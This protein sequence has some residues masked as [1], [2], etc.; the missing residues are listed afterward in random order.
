MIGSV[1]LL[2]AVIGWAGY[3]S[4]S[5]WR[6]RLLPNWI[7]VGGAV[8]ALVLRLAGGGWPSFVNGFAAAVM[9]GAF[10]LIP[11]LMRGAGGGDV[12]MLFAAGAMVGW[13]KLLLLLWT[14]SVAGL[15]MGVTML[16]LGQLDGA[17]LKHV[18]RSLFDWRY[19]RVAGAATLPPKDSVRSRIPF[20]V[21]ISIGL[22]V[23]LL[24]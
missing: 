16:L 4:W 14:T 17:R 8:V 20:S 7:T 6:T 13:S 22:V 10:L 12:K 18:A 9:A 2:M 19:D 1:L 11:F 15:V 24:G 23:A 21:P 5:D 3:L